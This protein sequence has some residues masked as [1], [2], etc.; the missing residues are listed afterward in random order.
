MSHDFQSTDSVRSG[1]PLRH[2]QTALFPTPLKLRLGGT[3]PSIE[4]A[5][6]TYGTLN[7]DRS[8][9]VLICH[10]ISGDSHVSRH[11][12]D[13]DPGWWETLV[14]P[15]KPVDTDR[16]FVICSNVLGGCR[17][18]T[19]PSTIDPSTGAPYGRDFPLI[20]V[21]DMVDVQKRLVDLLGISRL[22]A[23]VG[24]S[25]GGH[26]TLCWAT[27]YPEQVQTGVVLGSSSRLTS[28]ALA[29]DVVGRNAI[30]T[31]PMFHEG[32]YYDTGDFP[33]MGLAI[34]RMLGHITYLSSESMRKRF[35]VD[36]HEPRDIATQF[37]KRFSVGSYLAYQG[38]QF[39]G[40]FDANS[41]VAITLAM[42]HFDFGGNHEE[43]V[44][45]LRPAQCDWLVVSYSSDWLFPPAQSWDL[46][47]AMTWLNQDVSYC[48]IQTDGGHDGFLLPDDIEAYGPLVRAKLGDKK[49]STPE[50]RRS[51]DRIIELIP[52]GSSVLDLGCGEGD[53]LARLRER[54]DARLVGVEVSTS[55][56]V[57]TMQHGVDAID[58]DL[59]K[60]LPQFHDGTFDYV[61][62]SSTLQVVPNV[63]QLLRDS[64]RVGKR[65][66]V[67]FANFGHRALRTMFA[68]EGRVPKAPGPY[69]Y[70]WYDT[71]NRRFPSIRD[72][73]DLCDKMNVTVE[74]ARYYDDTKGIRIAESNDPNLNA[75]TAVLILRAR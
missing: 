4:V 55:L 8:N 29:F 72:V 69:A 59:N 12:E 60:G 2:L 67:S 1:K 48:E 39:V 5:Y 22:R 35:D 57:A 32:Q 62:I 10:A 56:I 24:G 74:D 49:P 63:E 18:T 6:E 13:D 70:E 19:G 42:D 17:G 31:D 14:G 41:Y 68:D 51:D 45:A 52:P 36:R 34:A 20:T 53:L 30:Q 11:D 73:L 33:H 47:A 25:L 23:V 16:F 44:R 58:C 40:R 75:D 37:E 15:G 64:L 65:A 21:E 66:I 3:L 46:V 26:Q 28:Q 50:R 7:P 9:A 43:R 38:D 61:V 54:G 71:P 27:R